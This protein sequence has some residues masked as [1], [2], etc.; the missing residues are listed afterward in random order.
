MSR[1]AW[2]RVGG[3]VVWGA[4]WYRWHGCAWGAPWH[5]RGHCGLGGM[6]AREGYRGMGARGGTAGWVAWA[7]ALGGMGARGGHCGLGG[8]AHPAHHPALCST[9]PTIL[10]YAPPRPPPCS[11]SHPAHHPALCP[12]PPTTLLCAPPRPPSCSVP[13]PVLFLYSF[14]THILLNFLCFLLELRVIARGVA[15]RGVA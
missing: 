7:G 10:L 14:I 1:V 5:G 4:P 2:E 3:T 9:P 8:M 15:Q 6:G 11:V 12:T 13:H